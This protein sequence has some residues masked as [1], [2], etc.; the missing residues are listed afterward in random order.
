MSMAIAVVTSPGWR[1]FESKQ[2]PL[3]PRQ[4]K[5]SVKV[6]LSGA[7]F[8]CADTNWIY[9]STITNLKSTIQILFLLYETEDQGVVFFN[10]IEF[11]A[12]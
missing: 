12:S 8:K 6:D 5:Q 3:P 10:N 9:K 4:W 2:F 7:D 11:G 1:Y